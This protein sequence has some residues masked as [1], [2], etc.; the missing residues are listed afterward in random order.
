M[1]SAQNVPA[2][3]RPHCP[4]ATHVV[5]FADVAPRDEKLPIAQPTGAAAP[6]GQPMPP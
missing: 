3:Q 2:A 6:P 1:V 5:Q 4:P